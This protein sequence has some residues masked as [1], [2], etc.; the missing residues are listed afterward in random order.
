LRNWFYCASAI[1]CRGF[2]FIS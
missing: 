1:C 2:L